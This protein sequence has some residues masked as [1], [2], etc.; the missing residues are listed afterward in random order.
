VVLRITDPGI[1][2]G[3]ARG[4]IGVFIEVIGGDQPCYDDNTGKYLE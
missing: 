1:Y 4:I 2:V 3:R